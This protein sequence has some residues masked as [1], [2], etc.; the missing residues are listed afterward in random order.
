MG[1]CLLFLGRAAAASYFCIST[2]IF[3]HLFRTF[4]ILFFEKINHSGKYK[5]KADRGVGD[6]KII[7]K[8]SVLICFSIKT[9]INLAWSFTI[10]FFKEL[11]ILEKKKTNTRPNGR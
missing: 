4:T 5:H 3:I 11:I 9:F 10:Q 7:F 6:E 2:K 8:C 1:Y